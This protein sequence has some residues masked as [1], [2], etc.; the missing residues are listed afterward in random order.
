MLS[1]CLVISDLKL[2][3]HQS[4]ILFWQAYFIIKKY[5]LIK[6]LREFHSQLEMH[7]IKV[8]NAALQRKSHIFLVN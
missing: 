4:H 5:G 3:K 7:M 2:Q 8:I 1:L 6:D